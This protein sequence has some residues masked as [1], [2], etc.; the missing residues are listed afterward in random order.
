M[1]TGARTPP[2]S[3]NSERMLLSGLLKDPSLAPTVRDMVGGALDFFRPEY[4]KLYRGIMNAAGD[5]GKLGTETLLAA[6]GSLDAYGGEAT[7]QGM[8]E[9]AP[10]RD[11]TLQHAEIV[12]EKA[13][14][15]ALLDATTAIMHDVYHSEES[16]AAILRSAKRRLNKLGK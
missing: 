1:S 7:I 13:K 15:R 14:L 3:V 5:D 10:D 8:I 11:T 4:G 9:A 12:A 2:Y 16:F 6:L